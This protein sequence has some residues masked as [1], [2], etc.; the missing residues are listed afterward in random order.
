MDTKLV[1]E[2]IRKA[3]MGGAARALPNPLIAPGSEID[4][5]RAE[6]D[7]EIESQVLDDYLAD[8]RHD[9]QIA[10]LDSALA[11]TVTGMGTNASLAP[12]AR[13]L[14]ARAIASGDVTGTVEAFRSYIEGNTAPM[15]AVMTV[16][17]V[18]T[19]REVRLGPDIR[20]VPTTSLAPS[21]QRG[22]ALGRPLLP[23]SDVRR[24]VSSALVTALDFGPIF[25]WPT[26][27]GGPSETAVEHAR[28]ALRDL[29][30]ARTLISLLGITTAMRMMWLQPKDPMMGTGA[31][32]GWLTSREVFAGK[33]IEVDVEAA[34]ELASTYFRMDP[35]RRQQ[36]LHIP[37]DRLDRA[38]RDDDLV[39]KSIDL[40]IALEALLLHEPGFQGELKFRLSLRGA[41][42]GDGDAKKRGETQEILEEVYNLRSRAV[43]TGRVDPNQTNYETI[44][45]GTSL[46]KQLIRK[47]IEADGR[48]EWT[49]LLVGGGPRTAPVHSPVLRPCGT[50]LRT[51]R[52]PS[53][54]LRH[55]Y[56]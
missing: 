10:R 26:E 7:V 32:A 51:R 1:E 15:I 46:C 16:S 9:Q 41:W 30:E 47:M 5:I 52:S 3:I 54:R 4:L 44:A 20:L 49:T 43:H 38:S 14:L 34:E 13:R 50:T 8:L 55:W 39:D 12:V 21:W 36:I 29:D 45:R 35:K 17:G 19:A 53:G 22:D 23:H 18:K 48:V 24:V 33:D 28:S 11:T 31:D 25:Y 56:T 37:L 42:L 2:A 27:G 40:G 6:T